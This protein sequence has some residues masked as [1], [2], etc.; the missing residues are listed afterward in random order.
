MNMDFKRKLPIPKD[1]KEMFPISEEYSLKR[2]EKI[3]EICVKGTAIG[4]GYYNNNE[5]TN[6]SFVQ[7]PLNKS[8]IDM[9][10][11]TG[12]LTKWNSKKVTFTEHTE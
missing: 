8:Y 6:K 4:L 11:K 2:K 5:Q 9:I 12:D 3:G 1:I 7:N 10:Y